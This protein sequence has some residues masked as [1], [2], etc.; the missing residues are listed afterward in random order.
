MR[1]VASMVLKHDADALRELIEEG[2]VDVGE[3]R[4]ARP[5]R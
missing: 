5:A 3:A 1:I 4:G 2:E